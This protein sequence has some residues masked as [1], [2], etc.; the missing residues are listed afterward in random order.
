MVCTS[1]Y[2]LQKF[3]QDA[4]TISYKGGFSNQIISYV[5]GPDVEGWND[6]G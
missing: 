6:N 4:M 3:L 2:Q 1:F 5:Y